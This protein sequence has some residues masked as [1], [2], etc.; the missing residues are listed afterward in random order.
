MSAG[1]RTRM[2]AD[3]AGVFLHDAILAACHRYAYRAAIVDTSCV[4]PSRRIS[5]AEFGDLMQTA[6][7]NLVA[8]GLKPGD[9]IAIY[10]SNSWEYAV[11]FH[12]A[13]LAGC[14]P[15]LLNPSYREREVRYQLENSGAAALI[16]DG[17]QIAD[18]SLAGLPNLKHLFTTRH[19]TCGSRHFAELLKPS[20]AHIPHPQ[21]SSATTLAALPYSSGT[22][23]L[24]KG[25]M[26]T[27][28][29]LLANCYQFLVPY[30][31]GSFTQDEV[32]LCFLPLY[33]I[34]G[35]NVILNPLLLVGGTNVL[36]PRFDCEK[37][38]ALL[39]SE[40]VTFLPVVPP[41]L[42]VLCNAAA[43][44]RFP[45]NHCVRYTKSGAAPLAPELPKRF[46][47]LTGIRV[48]QGYGMTEASPV[49]HLGFLEPHLYRPD[50]IGQ[51]V[52]ETD[53]R[54]VTDSGVDAAPG[55]P[56]ELVMRGP[57]FSYS[58]WKSPEA[59]REVFRDGWYWSGDVALR[60]EEGFYKIVDRRKE[61]IKYKGF[62]I[63]PA[64]VEAVLLEHPA[65]RD[66]GVIGL[67][68]DAAG[69][70]P[71]AFIVLN[72][73]HTPET[74]LETDLCGFVGERLTGY[75][76][77]RQVRFV[78]AIPRNPSGKILRKDLRAT[79]LTK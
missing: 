18:I 13:I 64:E 24:P 39:A 62:P 73:T 29:N 23:G 56:G 35:L 2:Y 76:Q 54:I 25:V 79:L 36:M 65:V 43:E 37:A 8:V 53:C 15:T 26:L 27:H 50:S 7:K 38:L 21:Q 14:V 30:E 74:A 67:P 60:D 77:P 12:A 22:T 48:R 10:L 46:A 69:E 51:E 71:C 63:A 58:Y 44:G 11:A 78:S 16:T 34:Y 5:Y 17:P 19:A 32:A 3:P 41:V 66:C 57:Q 40:E 28:H 68:D 55:E 72:P 9:I 33:H 6:A 52:A 42:N 1:Q 49:T 20:S 59:T 45:K 61:M 75:K 70:I 31:E 47:E 4:G